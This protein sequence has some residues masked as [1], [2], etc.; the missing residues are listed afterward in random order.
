MSKSTLKFIRNEVQ[1]NWLID[2]Y[3]YWYLHIWYKNY[4]FN[5]SDWKLMKTIEVRQENACNA[6]FNFNASLSLGVTWLRSFSECLAS[7]GGGHSLYVDYLHSLMR[8]QLGGGGTSL[9]SPMRRIRYRSAMN[10]LIYYSLIIVL[11]SLLLYLAAYFYIPSLVGI[12]PGSRAFVWLLLLYVN[13][14]RRLHFESQP[15]PPDATCRARS[16]LSC[17]LMHAISFL[18]WL[19][20]CPF[21]SLMHSS[22]SGSVR[23]AAS[24]KGRIFSLAETFLLCMPFRHT[25]CHT[26]THLVSLSIS[27]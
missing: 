23:R 26:H 27:T 12:A 15:P 17:R 20:W 19:W 4:F 5:S 7:A 6:S 9:H 18:W 2:I 22:G 14:A 11:M 8:V 25:M 16:N 10:A 21:T 24:D 3:W 13:G 1:K